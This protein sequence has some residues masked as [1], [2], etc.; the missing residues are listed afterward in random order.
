MCVLVLTR[1]CGT[2]FNA[3]SIQ[4]EDITE[5]CVEMEQT[6]PKGVLWFLVTELVVLFC[7]GDKMLVTACG[8]MKAMVLQEEPIRLHTTTP[9]TTHLRPYLAVRDRQPSGSQ[10]P[11]P[12]QQETAQQSSS[13]PHPDGR[14]PH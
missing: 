13:N 3:A 7:S 4:E 10:S 5:L 6:H 2:P 9:S 1:G 11:T 14:T 12:N 8:V